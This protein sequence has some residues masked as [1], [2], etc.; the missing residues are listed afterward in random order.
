MRTHQL[1]SFL[2]NFILTFFT[3]SWLYWTDYYSTVPKIQ[4]VSM[5]GTS[6]TILHDAGLSAPYGL[7]L[8]YHTQTLYWTD[9]SSNRIEMSNAD[10]SNRR[11]VTTSL[12]NDA[13]SIT[14]FNGRLYWTDFS[15]N[16]IITAPVSGGSSTYL[17]GATND[18]YGI[19]VVAEERQPLGTPMQAVYSMHCVMLI[20]LMQSSI[21]IF[22]V[23][24]MWGKPWRLQPFLS[25]EF[26]K[27]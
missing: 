6:K 19:T 17:T 20:N 5:D 18:M 15:Y 12:V 26:N 23:Q 3:T 24:S 22:S 16:R 4:R 7:T 1:Y 25:V 11:T 2:V 21:Y 10:G 9:Y 13:Y 27:G 14:F 8:D